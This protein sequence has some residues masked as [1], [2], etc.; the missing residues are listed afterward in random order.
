MSLS[1]DANYVIAL[2][3]YHSSQSSCAYLTATSC[4]GWWQFIE[5][6]ARLQLQSTMAINSFS[7]GSCCTCT[8]QAVKRAPRTAEQHAEEVPASESAHMQIVDM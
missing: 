6:D 3:H 5:N 2:R 7:S 1:F 4:L 8:G